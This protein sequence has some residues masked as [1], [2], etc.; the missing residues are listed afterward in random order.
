MIGLLAASSDT[1]WPDAVVT[2]AMMAFAA[3]MFWVIFR[4]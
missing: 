1:S 3:F 4:D 2:I